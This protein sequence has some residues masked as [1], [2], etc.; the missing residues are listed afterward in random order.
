MY[1]I[2]ASK[3]YIRDIRESLEGNSIWFEE[4][5]EFSSDIFQQHCQAAANANVQILIIEMNCTED[6]SL[7]RGIQQFRLLRDSRIILIAPGREPGDTTIT[8]LLGLQI[9]DIIA[10]M[11]DEK[12]EDDEEEE[13]GEETERPSIVP[14]IKKQL[15]M[16]PSY[17]NVV[18]WDVKTTEMA[19]RKQFE[20]DQEK[21]RKEKQKNIKR[22]FDP[23]L[24]L[25]EHIH[26]LSFEPPPVKFVTL[27]NRTILIGGLYPGAGSTFVT[28]T[29]ARLLNHLGIPNGVV[30]IPVNRPELYAMLYG[31]KNAPVTD[32]NGI[33]IP[34]IFLADQILKDGHAAFGRIEW[35]DEH[36]TWFPANP[37]SNGYDNWT[38]EHTFKLILSVKSPIILVDVSHQWQHPSVK[39]ICQNADEIVFVSDPF[40]S[41]FEWKET[42]S[43]TEL[44]A[45]LSKAGKSIHVVANRDIQTKQRNHRDDWIK[46]LPLPPTCVHPYVPYPSIIESIW[47]GGLVQDQEEIQE[48]LLESCFPLIR[49]LIPQSFPLNPPK[50]RAGVFSRFFK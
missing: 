20:L 21:F 32:D 41:K 7:I 26:S 16:K 42:I 49:E 10:P 22:G 28:L 34:Y 40:P 18:R 17:G 14:L 6:S 37:S 23:D 2:I 19:E 48:L 15:A 8:T 35:V 47:T 50:K 45:D 5:G 27:P 38:Y 33:E 11:R 36:T 4:S 31:E 30:E 29:I 43:N 24:E 1:G 39:Q 25:I 13:E 3:D 46:S 44:L 9:L 12:R